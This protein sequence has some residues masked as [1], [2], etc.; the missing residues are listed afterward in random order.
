MW[1]SHSDAALPAGSHLPGH[2]ATKQANY[3]LLSNH[4]NVCVCMCVC[5]WVG[6]ILNTWRKSKWLNK[7]TATNSYLEKW[8]DS[9]V[10]IQNTHKQVRNSWNHS[11]IHDLKWINEKRTLIWLID[12]INNMELVADWWILQNRKVT[13]RQA[14]SQSQAGD[15]GTLS[16]LQTG[17][18]SICNTKEPVYRRVHIQ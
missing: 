6:V 10:W 12:R 15:W 1:L 2:M 17:D 14:S 18:S 7:K 11:V 4:F 13:W 16:K 9:A 8:Y 5:C 3:D